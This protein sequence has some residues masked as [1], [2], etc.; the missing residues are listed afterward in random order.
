[1]KIKNILKYILPIYF[2]APIS[3]MFINMSLCCISGINFDNRGLIVRND[4]GNIKYISDNKKT[5]FEK[6]VEESSMYLWG[7][8]GWPITPIV[9]PKFYF[10]MLYNTAF[11]FPLFIHHIYLIKIKKDKIYIDP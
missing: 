10:E 2:T 6:N 3:C 7:L 1:M 9:M 4:S 8:V 5:P 11:T